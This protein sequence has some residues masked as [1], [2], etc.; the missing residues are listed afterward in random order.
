M[1]HPC[2]STCSVNRPSGG[3]GDGTGAAQGPVCAT[4]SP[5]LSDGTGARG[6][7]GG[8]ASAYPRDV[9]DVVAQQNLDGLD[10]PVLHEQGELGELGEPPLESVVERVPAG[11][12]GRTWGES[13]ERGG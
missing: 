1:L 4:G 5:G 6:L 12:N 3:P 7:G 13:G 10:L 11:G 8:G 2:C 9:N